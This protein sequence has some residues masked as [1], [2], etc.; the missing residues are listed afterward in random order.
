MTDIQ[1]QTQTNPYN[2]QTEAVISDKLSNCLSVVLYLC[3]I[4]SLVRFFYS[5][6]FF[7]PSLTISLAMAAI[8][9]CLAV[10]GSGCVFCFLKKSVKIV[11]LLFL[12]FIGISY[13][14]NR[15]GLEYIC[16]T[17]AFLGIMT[18]LPYARLNNDILKILTFV[19]AVFVATIAIFA[20]RWTGDSGKININTNT[21]GY[22]MFFFEVIILSFAATYKKGM[23]V[24]YFLVFL[25][26][27][28]IYFQFKF[29][30]RSTFIGTALYIFYLI[31]K[32]FFNKIKVKNLKLLVFA[33]SI[34]AVV[35]AYF[36]SVT[37]FNA[38]GKGN[39]IIFGKDIFTGRQT[40]WS[41]AFEKLKGNWLFGI[42][43]T[44]A[45]EGNEE[46]MY[47]LHNQTMG[48]L[49][50][51]GVIVAFLYSVLIA[52][53]TG[54]LDRGK[55]SKHSVAFVIVL[56]LLSF[57]ETCIYASTFIGFTTFALIIVYSCDTKIYN[58]EIKHGKDDTLLLVREK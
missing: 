55:K 49:T 27:V 47:N 6:T 2:K 18:F 14:I 58:E 44:L 57:L 43:N 4:L 52:M 34:L 41:L 37:L 3:L 48:Y 50:C 25:A 32:G 56:C 8:N 38:V 39:W 9:A 22:V 51:F 46:N 30:S 40:I 28:A 20:T 21:S 31:F 5:F 24:K 23:V 54:G 10:V 36:Y 13:L 53:L 7:T 33:L 12:A 26:L 35:F 16:N 42:G 19:Y 15:S 17:V 45:Q 29:E 1:N 11:W